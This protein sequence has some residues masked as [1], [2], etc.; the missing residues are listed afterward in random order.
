VE[1]KGHEIHNGLPEK[2]KTAVRD[3]RVFRGS[4]NDIDFL[5]TRKYI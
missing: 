3:T 5:L 4:E 2:M 1:S